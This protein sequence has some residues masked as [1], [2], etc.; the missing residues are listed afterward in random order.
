MLVAA[1]APDPASE[2]K[3]IQTLAPTKEEKPSS[4]SKDKKEEQVPL[5]PR[6]K[7]IAFTVPL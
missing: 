3:R 5:A 1:L 2:T 6:T 4:S 7:H